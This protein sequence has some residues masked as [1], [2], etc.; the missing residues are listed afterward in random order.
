MGAA[1]VGVKELRALPYSDW[2]D[3]TRNAARNVYGVI[4]HILLRLYT[5]AEL[6]G[7]FQEQG[8]EPL[9]HEQR[10]VY[11]STIQPLLQQ[12]VTFLEDAEHGL[13]VAST[14]HYL[15]ELLAGVVSYDPVGVLRMAYRIALAAE[16]TGYT[17][18]GMAVQ[19]VVNLVETILANHASVVREGEPL[20]DLL[21]LLTCFAKIGWPEA[22]RLVW[23]LDE[24]F[25]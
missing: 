25:K 4:D 7:Q 19:E 14:A 15:M 11:Y 21:G 22:L 18:D 13:I 2:T 6:R 1:I 3:E 23:R 20:Q 5:G 17:T 16:K 8:A 12:A 10:G 9:T 24:L